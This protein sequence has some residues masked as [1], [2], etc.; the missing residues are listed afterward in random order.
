MELKELEMLP[1][2]LLQNEKSFNK[3]NLASWGM[4]SYMD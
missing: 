2:S 3:E 1:Q 4:S